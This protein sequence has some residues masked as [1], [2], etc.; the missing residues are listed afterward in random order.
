MRK[1]I[2]TI[3]AGYRLQVVFG[4]LYIKIL[5]NRLQYFIDEKNCLSKNQGSG[6]K[7]SRTSDH[8]LVIKFFIDKVVKSGKKKLYT[9]FVDVK[10]AYDCTLRELLWY[11]LLTEYGVGGNF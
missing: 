10:K 7:L 9:C 5:K 4:K 8:L 11:K 6:K 3:F 1:M 2:P